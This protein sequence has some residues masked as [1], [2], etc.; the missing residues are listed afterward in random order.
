MK[1]FLLPAL[2][3]LASCQSPTE[4]A[5]PAAEDLALAT[6]SVQTENCLAQVEEDA[7]DDPAFWLHPTQ[8]EKSL[9]F[10]SNKKLGLEVY[11][12]N[13]TRLAHYPTGRLN[14]VDVALNVPMGDSTVDI[15]AA[16]N[17]DF[18]RIDIWIINEEATALKLVSDTAMRTQ[19]KGVYGFCLANVDSATYAFVNSKDGDVEQWEITSHGDL[20]QFT[21]VHAFKA[22]GQVEG[23]VVDHKNKLLYLG[24]E[25]GGVFAYAL[26]SMSAPRFRIPLSGAE[27]TDLAYDIEGLAIYSHAPHHLLVTSSQGNHKYAVYNIDENYAYLGVFGVQDT[28]GDRT[29]ETDGIDIYSG[30]VGPNYPSGIFF[31]Q[32]GFNYDSTGTKEPQNFKLVDWRAIEQAMGW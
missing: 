5:S 31:C 24:E 28:H 21:L 12:L 13:G 17:R 18:D 27:N 15:V 3:L 20:F 11:N 16:S 2:A 30:P 29:Q 23:M 10:G 9:V 7:A 32:D 8:P 19:L 1:K 4:N 14:N 25:Q 22:A 6:A 26:D